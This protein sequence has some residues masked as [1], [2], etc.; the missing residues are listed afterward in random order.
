MPISIAV[1]INERINLTQSTG[2][3]VL[4]FTPIIMELNFYH[5]RSPPNL[6]LEDTRHRAWSQ[7]W[8]EAP[9]ILMTLQVGYGGVKYPTG[10]PITFAR[11]RKKKTQN[12]FIKTNVWESHL[13]L[14]KNWEN[15]GL[16]K[17][18]VMLAQKLTF[19]QTSSSLSSAGMH[20]FS[21]FSK[22]QFISGSNISAMLRIRGQKGK[23]D[24]ACGIDYIPFWSPWG[25][26]RN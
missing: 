13:C 22:G 17:K 21:Y 18:F 11:G 23:E 3:C 10:F 16:A 9:I 15:T 1:I 5:V 14:F 4:P 12:A 6:P 2:P 7:F 19:C 26:L 8:N 24:T 20:D 25:K